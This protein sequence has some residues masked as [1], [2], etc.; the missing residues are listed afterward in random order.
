MSFQA[1][2]WVTYL[3]KRIVTGG[4]RAVLALLADRANPDGTAAWPTQDDLARTLEVTE[5]SIRRYLVELETAGLIRRGD[6][7]YVSHIRP[8]RRPVV[9]DLVMDG[10]PTS[11][12][13][14]RSVTPSPVDNPPRG[15]RSVPP[16]PPPRG[17][18][19]GSHGGTGA[20]RHGGT[21]SVLENSPLPSRTV[22]RAHAREGGRVAHP[23]EAN[24]RR[25]LATLRVE[26]AL[27]LDVDEL[28]ELAYGVGDGDPWAGYLEVK[29][30]S[31]SDLE[32]A[33][34]VEAVLRSRL[35]LESAPI[36]R[37]SRKR[38]RAK[39]KARR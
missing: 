27:P 7:R 22:P 12:R 30:A 10:P 21:A 28:I 4:P 1:S 34:N 25:A 15:D 29:Q 23:F 31:T 3:P 13:G 11:P 26:R 18:S 37:G 24:A 39:R 35:G 6:Q 14:D 16:F 17:D 5:R 32:T 2:N 9:W 19:H 36:P 33:R 38:S 20:V 8:D